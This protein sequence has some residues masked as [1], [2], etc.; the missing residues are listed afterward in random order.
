L[1]HRKHYPKSALDNLFIK[2][3]DLL[4]WCKEDFTNLPE[5]WLESADPD[6]ALRINQRTKIAC[7]V[8]AEQIWKEDPETTI[9]DMVKHSVI[10][11]YGGRKPYKDDTVR[12][13]LT[14]V[15]PESI[16]NRRGR[17]K[18]I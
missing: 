5:F 16:K 4:K 15:A 18:K 7:Q 11:R 9:A 10:Q 17:P 6:S 1:T 3:S 8:I 14:E 12:D 13:W 2:R